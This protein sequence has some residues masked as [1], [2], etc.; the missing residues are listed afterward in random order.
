MPESTR[1]WAEK[2]PVMRSQWWLWGLGLLGFGAAAAP[3]YVGLFATVGELYAGPVAFGVGFSVYRVASGSRN[4]RGGWEYHRRRSDRDRLADYGVVASI[5]VSL[6]LAASL[7]VDLAIG[8]VLTQET[9]VADPILLT[10]PAAIAAS[11][12]AS[13]AAFGL[14]RPDYEDAAADR[15]GS[16]Q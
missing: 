10:E 3:L 8:T 2:C 12:V 11:L 5:T 13:G 16:E 14:R 1:Q 7:T 6:A 4:A 9:F 15:T